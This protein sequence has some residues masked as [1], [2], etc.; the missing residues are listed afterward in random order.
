[1]H[2]NVHLFRSSNPNDS[3]DGYLKDFEWPMYTDSKK[4]YLEIGEN[5]TKIK[6][7]IFVDRFQ[8]WDS[9]FPLN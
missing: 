5:L 1:M 6:G 2:K 9:L 7:G 4:E 3:K 8:L